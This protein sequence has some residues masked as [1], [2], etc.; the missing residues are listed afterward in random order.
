MGPPVI[1]KI[2]G[3]GGREEARKQLRVLAQQ[4]VAVAGDIAAVEQDFGEHEDVGMAIQ[5]ATER[6]RTRLA[7]PQDEDKIA[8]HFGAHASRH[9]RC[10][11][12]LTIRMR[13]KSTLCQSA[14]M[15]RVH[16]LTMSV[17]MSAEAGGRPGESNTVPTGVDLPAPRALHTQL[18]QQF[19]IDRLR[20][21]K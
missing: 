9:P 16:G 4:L 2:L 8:I 7:R 20:G 12:A 6:V 15:L 18:C 17:F 11:K 10:P 13:E 5:H 1:L 3:P 19:E 21:F 14:P